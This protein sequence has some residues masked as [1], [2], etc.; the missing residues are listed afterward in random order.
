MVI[1]DVGWLV[2]HALEGLSIVCLV[3]WLV[4]GFVFNVLISSWKGK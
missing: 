3:V 1:S 2:I 4:W